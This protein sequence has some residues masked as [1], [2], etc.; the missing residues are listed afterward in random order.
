MLMDRYEFYPEGCIEQLGLCDICTKRDK[1]TIYKVFQLYQNKK[2]G[3]QSLLT[4]GFAY[5]CS[6]DC[7]E[8]VEVMLMM[9]F[10]M[11]RWVARA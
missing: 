10:R 1:L 11:R 3:C 8:P 4:V 2:M 5:V 7:L 6:P 9:G